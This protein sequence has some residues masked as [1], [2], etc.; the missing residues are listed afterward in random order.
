MKT[1]L[2]LSLLGLSFQSFAADSKVDYSYCKETFAPE[3]PGVPKGFPF[4]MKDDGTIKPHKKANY[5]FDKKTNTETISYEIPGFNGGGGF[6]TTSKPQKSTVTIM[7]KRDK[8]GK[9]LQVSNQSKTEAM[10]TKS[11]LGQKNMPWGGAGMVGPGMGYPGVGFGGGGYGFGQGFDYTTVFDVKYKSGK[12]FPHRSVAKQ[13]TGNHEHKSFTTDIE[14][15]RDLKKF[16]AGEKKKDSKQAKLKQCYESYQKQAQKVLDAHLE[17]N[18]DLYNPDGETG[19]DSPWGQSG[20]FGFNDSDAE[21]S[22]GTAGG[23][24]YG[25]YGGF[26][27]SID[28]IVQSQQFSSAAKAKMLNAYCS[29]P[30]GPNKKMIDDDSLYVKDE[31]PA[32]AGGEG[33]GGDSKSGKE[34]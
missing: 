7:I 31:V 21:F 6:P 11:G 26:A 17:R 10:K 20:P 30:Y 29:F 32:S 25:G 15:C 27:G 8:E 22:D 24:A 13:K 19:D 3:L 2:A 4:E 5:K 34:K 14:L 18:D 16:Y 33:S 28:N 1:F 12:C 9:I 23:G